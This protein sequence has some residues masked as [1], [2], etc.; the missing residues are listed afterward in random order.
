MM[1]VDVRTMGEL[2][3]LLSCMVRWVRKGT[4]TYILV[5]VHCIQSNAKW[6]GQV[7]VWSKHVS[8]SGPLLINTV[9]LLTS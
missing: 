4:D 6:P 8:N 3:R 5:H 2:I 1:C 9:S 7:Y